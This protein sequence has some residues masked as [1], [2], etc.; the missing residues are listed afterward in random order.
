MPQPD[1]QPPHEDTATPNT[2][3]PTFAP[4]RRSMLYGT[5]IG[6]ASMV[7]GQISRSLPGAATASAQTEPTS[8]ANPTMHAG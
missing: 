8:A 5:G 6:A 7:A 2:D 1:S 4:T 3:L